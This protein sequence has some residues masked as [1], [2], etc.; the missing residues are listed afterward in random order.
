LILMLVQP[1]P[2]M[3]RAMHKSANGL[4]L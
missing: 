1:W 2:M 3:P 4:S